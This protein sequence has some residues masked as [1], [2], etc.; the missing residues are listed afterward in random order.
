MPSI[1]YKLEVFEG[2]MDLLL[3]LIAKRKLNI[4]DIPIFE[5]V[6]QYL[7][8]IRDMQEANLDMA[9]EFLEMA[10]RLVY[11]KTLSLLPS[12]EEGEKLRMELSGE[13]VEYAECK[14]VALLL[15]A[16]TKGFDFISRPPGKIEVN[17][18]Y[19]RVHDAIEL[20]YAYTRAAGK[21]LRAL[22]PPFEVFKEI[23]VKKTVSVSSKIKSIA[24]YLKTGKRKKFYDIIK[25]SISRSDMIATFLAI[26]ELA[27]TNHIRLYGNGEN[28]E[29]ELLKIPEEE[30]AFE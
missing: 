7:A 14:R 19:S 28:V 4:Y 3:C 9:S 11:I 23:V 17:M 24:A 8:Y 1:S 20:L 18:T 15:S 29:L 12:F 25:K 22:P 13:L 26:L 21:R 5:L 16:K 10:A 6:E 30:L 27:K 2:P